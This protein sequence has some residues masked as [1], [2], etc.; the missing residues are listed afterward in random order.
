MEGVIKTTTSVV[1][2]RKIDR[3]DVAG[4]ADDT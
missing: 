1:L 4:P 3:G 2:A